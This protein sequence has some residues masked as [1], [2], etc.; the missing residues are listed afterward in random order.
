MIGGGN[1][2]K[3]IGLP[4]FQ[5]KHPID[6]IWATPSVTIA[7]A[8]I[9]PTGCGIRDHYLFVINI[10]TSSLIGRRPPRAC[11]AA[12]RW[13]NTQLL[14]HNKNYS[15]SLKAKI[16]QHHLIDKMGKTHT[17]RT[18]EEVTQRR[19]NCIDEEGVQCMIQ[20]KQH[21]RRLKSGRICFLLES[22][23]WVKRKQIYCSLVEYKLGRSK[24]RGNLK[25]AA[26]NQN[27]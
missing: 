8:Y 19:I 1:M 16:L 18:S 9:M 17:L 20:A 22:V 4:L 26:R 3:K 25:Q 14:H 10:H 6:G 2:G 15:P 21:C 23:I 11:R 27:F 12:S 5:G 24:N 7:Y 13:L